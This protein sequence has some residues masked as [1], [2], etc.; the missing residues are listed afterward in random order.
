MQQPPTGLSPACR[1]AMLRTHGYFRSPTLIAAA[2]CARLTRD[3]LRCA[4]HGDPVVRRGNATF[5]TAL[6]RESDTAA[7]LLDDAALGELLDEVLGEDALLGRAD[8]VCGTIPAWQ[9]DFARVRRDLSARALRCGVSLW[10]PLRPGGGV[11]DVL[12]ASQHATGG[13]PEGSR[14]SVASEPVPQGAAIVLEGGVR[15][16]VPQADG[17]WFAMSFVRPWI[18]PDVLYATALGDAAVR[19]L[20]V[21]GRRWCGLELGL[22]T[23]VEEFLA[24]EAAAVAGTAATAKGSGI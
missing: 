12:V 11:M 21:R 8:G 22:P 13:A 14:L 20:G 1:V 10:I 23:S 19:R 15:F 17:E 5:A 16:R 4:E 18:K 6:L 3:I 9:H 2:A 24:I 7:A